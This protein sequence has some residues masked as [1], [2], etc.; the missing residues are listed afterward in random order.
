MCENVTSWKPSKIK[1]IS[2]FNATDFLKAS[3]S[4]IRAIYHSFM[5]L[6]TCLCPLTMQQ[7]KGQETA[8]L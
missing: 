6:V 2:C 1:P 4:A 3:S 5:S 8:L 7:A